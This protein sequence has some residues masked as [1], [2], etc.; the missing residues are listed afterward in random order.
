MKLTDTQ[1]IILSQ[2]SQRPDGLAYPPERLPAA[3]RQAVAKA[4][5]K[6]DLVIAVH[7][8]AHDAVALWTVD[9]DSVLLKIAD[10]GL[11]AIGVEPATP[12]EE[13]EQSEAAILRRNA[14]R[15]ATAEAAAPVADR[16]P[17][18]GE[19]TAPE[20]APAEDAETAQTASLA[21]DLALPDEALTTPPARRISLRD[22]A[23]RVLDAW[24]DEASQRDH[25]ADAIEALRGILVRPGREARDPAA[26]RKPREGTKQAQVL[27]MLRRPEGATVAQIAEATGW[28]PHTVRGFFAGLKKRQGIAVE[29]LERVRQVGPNKEGA[30]GSFT[31]YHLPG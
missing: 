26:P 2:A 6:H 17:L 29:V 22:A 30:K 23:Q 21:E 25:L 27:A 5:L 24:D 15:R 1:R 16:A 20:D 8:P 7:R 14:E 11:R 4:L 18:G 12:A 3:A 19:D 13:D 31:I 10:E 28:A 9:G